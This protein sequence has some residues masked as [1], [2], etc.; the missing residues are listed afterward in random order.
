MPPLAED[1]QEN[2]MYAD[3]DYETVQS[4]ED[5]MNRKQSNNESLKS[6]ISYIR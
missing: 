3:L 6:Q 5:V 1:T 2:E 4:M